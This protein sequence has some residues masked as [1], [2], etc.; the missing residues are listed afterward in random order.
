MKQFK[1]YG[2][3]FPLLWLSVTSSF[4]A[5]TL[6]D[7]R[8]Q[9]WKKKAASGNARAQYKLGNYYLHGNGVKVDIKKAMF[10]FKKSAAQGN[11]KA[12][13]RL[14]VIYYGNL[15]GSRNY[16]RASRWFL[17]A[18]TKGHA[19]SQYYLA[20]MYKD[21]Q[22]VRKDP[23]RS[24]RW[25]KKAASAGVS[26]AKKLIAAHSTGVRLPDP[27]TSRVVHKD[28]AAPA[29]T[30]RRHPNRHRVATRKL[31]TSHK[32]ST[33]EKKVEGVLL[34]LENCITGE[35]TIRC[36][37][38]RMKSNTKDY[39]A[40]YLVETLFRDFDSS[41]RFIVKY[42]LNY[43]FV[44]PTDPDDPDPKY[45]IPAMGPDKTITMHCQLVGRTRIKCLNK[46]SNKVIVYTKS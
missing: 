19:M 1:L 38:K 4:A 37:S 33:A 7:N 3:V 11:V 23:K 6:Y 45:Y 32:W 27:K 41:G 10:W 24:L 8:F 42:R 14:G 39:M 36:K 18:A 44:M 26:K 31:L 40:D 15:D 12:A 29:R 2:I 25:A 5:D 16:S 43:L 46:K 9:E 30:A 22:G 17:K 20:L 34:A 21:G 35:K 28:V 13:Y